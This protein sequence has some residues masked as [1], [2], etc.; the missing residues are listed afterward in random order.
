MY[1]LHEISVLISF[2]KINLAVFGITLYIIQ[3]HLGLTETYVEYCKPCQ[4]WDY[5]LEFTKSSWS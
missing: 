3:C 2:K 1:L 4:I 5:E